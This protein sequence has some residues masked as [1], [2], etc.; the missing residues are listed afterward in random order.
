MI[1]DPVIRA[2]FIHEFRRG[3][4][5]KPEFVRQI[6]SLREDD[7]LAQRREELAEAE[8]RMN[9]AYDRSRTP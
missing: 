4:H 7:T 9:A 6:G 3:A 5:S 8:R 1:A 2:C